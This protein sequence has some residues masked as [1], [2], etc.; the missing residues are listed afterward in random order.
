MTEVKWM[1]P[2]QICQ[3]RIA[4]YVEQINA[5]DVYLCAP[6]AF[7]YE[8]DMTHPQEMMPSIRWD[9]RGNDND[10]MSS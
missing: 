1:T 10:V 5:R 2:C 4:R 8:W 6:C 7:A 3:Q 9:L